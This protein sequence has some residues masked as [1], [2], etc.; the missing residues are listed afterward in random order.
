MILDLRFNPGGLL[1]AAWEISDLLL[2]GNKIIVKTAGENSKDWE[3]RSSSEHTDLP[4][5]VLVN[6]R[7][8]SASEIG[9]RSATRAPARPACGGSTA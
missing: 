1:T 3:K 9:T 4:L 7:S 8:A 5:I 6:E 2:P